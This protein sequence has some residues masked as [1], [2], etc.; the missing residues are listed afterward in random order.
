MTTVQHGRHAG[1][2]LEGP[3]YET[4]YAFGGLCLINSIEEIAYLNDIC[5][6][7]GMDTI[8]AGNLCAFTIEAARR[9]KIDYKIDY[10]DVDSIA[11]LLKKIANPH[12]PPFNKGGQGGFSPL[13]KGRR[14]DFEDIGDILARGIRFAARKWDLEDIAVHVKG[15]EPPGYDPRVLKGMGLGYA[16]SDRGACHLR[17]TFYKPEL[18]GMID[19]D[20]IEGKAK[21]FVDFEDRLTIFDTL[22]LCRF[23]RDL[24][25]W[26]QLNEIIHLTTGLEVNIKTLQEKAAA[27]ST[28]VRHFNIREGLKPEDD[29]LPKKI[30]RKLKKTEDI[31]TEQELDYMLKD[32]YSLRGWDEKG[33]PQA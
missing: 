2:K 7:L 1:L 30:Y 19:P 23:Y 32:Y 9:G 17:A 20:V 14:E 16:T 13:L 10:G 28:L 5:D 27:I 31:I 8:T 4:I 25:P 22:I 11:E 33:K 21:L 15:L 6:R 18:S 24:Y 29:Q 26:E 12:N 3:E